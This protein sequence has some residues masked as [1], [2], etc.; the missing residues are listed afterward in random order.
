VSPLP[1]SRAPV[2]DS[3]GRRSRLTAMQ[4]TLCFGPPQQ[5]TLGESWQDWVFECDRGVHLG[6]N[7][8]RHLLRHSVAHFSSGWT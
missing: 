5:C 2:A 4:T 6:H 7:C 3:A 8:R 1:G